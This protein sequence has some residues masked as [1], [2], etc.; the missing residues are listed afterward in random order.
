MCLLQEEVQTSIDDLVQ[1][2]NDI[3][4]LNCSQG[5]AVCPNTGLCL[6]VYEK[7]NEFSQSTALIFR[8]ITPIFYT[9]HVTGTVVAPSLSCYNYKTI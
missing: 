3:V 9:I 4:T 6:A 8:I 2:K 5:F 7:W 1:I